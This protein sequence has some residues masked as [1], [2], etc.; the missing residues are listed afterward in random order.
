MRTVLS[1]LRLPS[2]VLFAAGMNHA[3][4]AQTTSPATKQYATLG[5]PA[6]TLAT[7]DGRY[8]LVSETNVD[9]PNFTGADA[10]AGTRKDVISGVQV[11]RTE[12][13]ELTPL[14]FI[15]IG[16]AGANGLVLLPGAKTLVVG[17]GDS[18]VAFLDVDAVLRGDAVPIFADQGSA[19]GTFDIVASKDG[20][21]IFSANEYGVIDGQRGNVGI[22]ATNIDA[23]G[24]VQ[25]P[26]LI[27]HIPLGDVVPSLSLSA[28]GSHLYVATEIPPA[29][30]S[31]AIAGA[32]NPT[33]SRSDCVQG[34]GTTPKQGGYISVIDTERA[35]HG[36]ANPVLLRIA[37]G[38][39]PVRIVESRN[40][41]ALFVS[42][43][44]DNV[45]LEFDPSKLTHDPEHAFRRAI[46][47]GGTAPVG[48]HLFDHDRKLAVAN[49][50]RFDNAP[51]TLALFDLH[52][53]A[54]LQA[55]ILPAGQFPRNLSTSSDGALLYLT[56]FSSRTV[57]VIALK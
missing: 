42:A 18:G 51:G 24:H 34:K 30:H 9:G 3:S 20:R 40:G 57:Q 4:I 29:N 53:A 41:S 48:L 52:G 33:L 23:S 2:I 36:D 25:H 27:G 39:S 26:N 6:S 22:T 13:G 11:F 45:V 7:P 14:Q 54:S 10:A 56:N 49:S 55:K 16:G 37:S 5:N 43:R 31:V 32:S 19:A 44:G 12:H 8:L 47:T 28:N 38:C 46:P 21:Y 1:L 17:V 50:N 35:I 15:K